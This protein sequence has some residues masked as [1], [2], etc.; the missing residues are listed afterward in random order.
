MNYAEWFL[1]TR[2]PTAA[3]D[4]VVI[5]N[6][7]NLPVPFGPLDIDRTTPYPH[8]SLVLL[9][10]RFKLKNRSIRGPKDKEA[11]ERRGTADL[12]IRLSISEIAFSSSVGRS[13]SRWVDLATFNHS[14]RTLLFYPATD[15]IQKSDRNLKPNIICFRRSMEDC[16]AISLI[17]YNNSFSEM[18]RWSRENLKRLYY[19]Q[20]STSRLTV[21]FPAWNKTRLVH[22]E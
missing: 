8:S 22:R 6:N 7:S 2:E 12:W 4:N 14:S 15:D 11:N 21:N 16:V 9:R 1:R 19:F 18:C 10:S 17:I 13:V 20:L 3:S 5:G